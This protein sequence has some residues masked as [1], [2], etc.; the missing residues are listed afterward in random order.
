MIDNVTRLRR[1][2]NVLLALETLNLDAADLRIQL[3]VL[4]RRAVL[5]LNEIKLPPGNRIN[6]AEARQ[7][8]QL[9]HRRKGRATEDRVLPVIKQL[10]ALGF[11]TYAALADE[12]NRRGIHPPIAD[13]WS[14]ST[15]YRVEN[16][17]RPASQ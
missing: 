3:V 16:R 14:A 4:K 2:R 7:K 17:R 15:L 5:A 11:K 9:A 13:E 6:L 8:A 10:R 12:L 1:L